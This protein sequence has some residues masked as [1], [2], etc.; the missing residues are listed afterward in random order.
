[1]NL[2]NL[3]VFITV[4]KHGNM[5]SAAK[6]LFITQ[7]T[8]SQIILSLEQEYDVILFDRFPKHL[9]LTEAGEKFLGYAKKVTGAFESLEEA[10][11]LKDKPTL[12]L[13]AT[14]TV[15]GSILADIVKLYQENNEGFFSKVTVENTEKIEEMILSGEIDFGIVE[16]EIRNKL[17]ETIPVFNDELVLICSNNHKFSK[18]KSIELSEL[19]SEN[20][21]MREKGSGTR[22]LLEMTLESNGVQVNTLWESHC[23]T[24]IM[25]AVIN[26][27]GVSFLSPKSIGVFIETKQLTIVPIKNF[28]INRK[29]YLCKH[30]NR[31]NNLSMTLFEESLEIFKNQDIKGNNGE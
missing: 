13:G 2:K 29:F 24:A 30:K 4:A 6:E 26:N 28:K 1:M 21:L 16:G 20:F 7:P 15:A 19:K 12:N 27:L 22:E 18:K 5:S 23:P 31:S 10:M 17:I 25:K 3:T 9:L 14:F 8:V 11:K